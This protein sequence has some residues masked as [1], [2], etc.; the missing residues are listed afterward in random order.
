MSNQSDQVSKEILAAFSRLE[1]TAEKLAE[2]I[3]AVRAERD[4]L[5]ELLD[6]SMKE[7][8]AERDS[9]TQAEKEVERLQ[10]ALE[11]ARATQADIEGAAERQRITSKEAA[12]RQ[13]LLELEVET[14]KEKLRECESELFRARETAKEHRS[15]LSS[16]EE[17]VAT[18]SGE[19]ERELTQLRERYREAVVLAEARAAEIENLGGAIVE[20]NAKLDAAGNSGFNLK[21]ITEMASR[22]EEAIGLIDKHIHE[23]PDD[24]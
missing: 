15:T 6:Q 18:E 5:S 9:R 12:Q 2:K 13:H 23:K 22:V 10:A 14:V 20:L 7:A 19:R 24:A 21:E 3:V 1:K 16:M 8:V 4:T 17:Q 11:Q